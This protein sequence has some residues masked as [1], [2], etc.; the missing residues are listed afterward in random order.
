METDDGP[1]YACLL[2]DV[3]EE[4]TSFEMLNLYSRALE[5]TSNGVVIS[6]MSLPGQPLFY[7]NPA[8]VTT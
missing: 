8:P 2:R 1:L 7:A 3:T 6:D 4:R 5:C